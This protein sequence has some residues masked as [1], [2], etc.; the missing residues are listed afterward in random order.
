LAPTAP[1]DG[2]LRS[3][4]RDSEVSEADL[5]LRIPGS[6]DGQRLEARL[7]RPGM[8]GPMPWSQPPSFAP[9]LNDPNEL[10]R[11]IEQNTLNTL[12]WTRI[13]GV[14]LILLLLIFGLAAFA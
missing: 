7:P 14:A 6:S 4:G 8:T 10:L 1:V 13:T 9:Q 11:R 12:Y 3:F 2:D 5:G